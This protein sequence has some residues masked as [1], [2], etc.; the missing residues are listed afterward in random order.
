MGMGLTIFFYLFL[1]SGYIPRVLSGLGIFASL[2]VIAACFA[3]FILPEYTSILDLAFIPTGLS[4]V[5]TGLWRMVKELSQ[6][7]PALKT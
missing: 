6:E 5:T 2:L 1:R 4:E 3:K 7:S